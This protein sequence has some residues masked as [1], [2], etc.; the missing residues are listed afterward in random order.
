M[1]KQFLK[2]DGKSQEAFNTAQLGAVLARRQEYLLR[3][4]FDSNG[5]DVLSYNPETLRTTPIQI[6]SRLSISRKYLGKN[7]FIAFPIWET[8]SRQAWYLLP[9]DTLAEIWGMD[10]LERHLGWTSGHLSKE[11]AE[12]L[13]PYLIGAV[14]LS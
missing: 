14:D 6:K 4:P 12:R 13:S 3:L 2:F 10:K 8:E 11:M 7:L 5:A 1:R 9:H